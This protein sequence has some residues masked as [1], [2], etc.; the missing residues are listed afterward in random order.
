MTSNAWEVTL[1]D[2]EN[3][4]KKHGIVDDKVI[5]AAYDMIDGEGVEDAVL[6]YVSFHDQVAVAQSEIEDQLMKLGFILHWSKK[7]YPP[8][9]EGE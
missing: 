6:H 4:L 2:L 1:E 5:E 9:E 8:Q 3:I 7:F